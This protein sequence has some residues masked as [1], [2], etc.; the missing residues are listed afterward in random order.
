M[1]HGPVKS[2]TLND[3]TSAESIGTGHEPSSAR[4]GTHALSETAHFVKSA[5]T[6]FENS[7]P[8]LTWQSPSSAFPVH[9]WMQRRL[10]AHVGSVTHR[11]SGAGQF[12][13]R[14]A[15]MAAPS[16]AYAGAGVMTLLPNTSSAATAPRSASAGAK[17]DAAALVAAAPSVG[18]VREGNLMRWGEWLDVESRRPSF[19]HEQARDAAGHL[20]ILNLYSA[21]MHSITT[22]L[23]AVP[24]AA[25]CGSPPRPA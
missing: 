24:L 4:C 11:A 1:Y 10:A 14:H 13:K 9:V 22:L 2:S 7:S 3:L 19:G 12:A 23:L 6:L 15:P 17:E 5:T 21:G 8:H 25:P 18:G 16:I 20:G